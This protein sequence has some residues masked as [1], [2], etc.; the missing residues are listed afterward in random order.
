MLNI[1]TNC[2][3]MSKTLFG[4]KD[5]STDLMGVKTQGVGGL[6]IKRVMIVRQQGGVG[7][8]VWK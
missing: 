8:V 7:G 4:R 5:S 3:L 2:C 1:T 6:S